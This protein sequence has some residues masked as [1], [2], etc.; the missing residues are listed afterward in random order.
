MFVSDPNPRRPR[1]HATG[2]CGWVV[3]C[4]QGNKRI[5]AACPCHLD[6]EGLAD[7][8]HRHDVT[9]QEIEQRRLLDDLHDQGIVVQVVMP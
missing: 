3:Y 8:A 5:L 9:D 7:L 4:S 1:G 6:L 2:C